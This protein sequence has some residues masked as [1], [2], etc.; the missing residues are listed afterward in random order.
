MH[1]LDYADLNSSFNLLATFSTPVVFFL[2][3]GSGLQFDEF[4]MMVLK[5]NTGDIFA[6]CI[7]TTSYTIFQK[8]SWDTTQWLHSG[9]TKYKCTEDLITGSI[10]LTNPN[11]YPIDL[12]SK[13]TAEQYWRRGF[14]L[15]SDRQHKQLSLLSWTWT[16]LLCHEETQLAEEPTLKDCFQVV[17][18]T[19]E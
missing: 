7:G 5:K 3:H 17:S 6:S 19:W 12:W 10:D 16:C 2:K 18:C 9:D 15:N 4:T 1:F 8:S 11:P 14:S 13:C